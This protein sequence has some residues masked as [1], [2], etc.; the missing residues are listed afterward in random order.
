M[1]EVF[2]DIYARNAWNGGS[3]PG[4]DPT[5][6]RPLVAFL[7]TYVRVH[8]IGSLCDL[9]C[10]DLQWIPEVIENTGIRYIG[11]DCVT[12]LLAEHRKTYAAP[13]YTFYDGD[14]STMPI[15]EFP[16]ASVYFIKDVLQH[17]PSENIR[18]FL[19]EFFCARPDAHFLTVN[20]NHQTS[21]MRTLD[22][23]YHFAPLNG[24]Y[25]PL[26]R[27]QPEKLLDWGGK[28]LYRLRGPLRP[29]GSL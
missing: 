1:K 24:I 3:G 18:Q 14:V 7:E 4:S 23:Q 26:K 16:L 19:G 28:T 5:F 12:G 8:N 20:C 6:C 27:F 17:W 29:Q 22:A 21:D 9:G 13:R 2:T 11:V 10:G 15:L 25:E